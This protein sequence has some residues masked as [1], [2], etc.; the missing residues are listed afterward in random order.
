MSKVERAQK[1]S[2]GLTWGDHEAR[3]G[4]WSASALSGQRCP[5]DKSLAVLCA[6]RVGTPLLEQAQLGWWVLAGPGMWG[7]AGSPQTSPVLEKMEG[8][9]ADPHS[10]LTQLLGV[11][12]AVGSS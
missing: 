2:W 5:Q 9:S 1:A 11:I 3:R 7:L 8:W 4:V 6:G 10:R 12:S